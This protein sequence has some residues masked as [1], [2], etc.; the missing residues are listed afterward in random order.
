M[1]K[2]DGRVARQPTPF[3]AGDRAFRRIHTAEGQ[4]A[5]RGTDGIQRHLA[6]VVARQLSKRITLR[7][8]EDSRL[9]RV[10]AAVGKENERHIA[11]I[12]KR[13]ERRL[14]CQRSKAR[15]QILCVGAKRELVRD[16]GIRR[17]M[18]IRIRGG[19]GHGRWS[20]SSRSQERPDI[21]DRNRGEERRCDP[22]RRAQLRAPPDDIE[23]EGRHQSEG[24]HGRQAVSRGV[25]RIHPAEL[26]H[27]LHGG[28]DEQRK[29]RAPPACRRRNAEKYEQRQRNGDVFRAPWMEDESGSDLERRFR[30]ARQRRVMRGEVRCLLALVCDHLRQPARGIDEREEPHDRNEREGQHAGDALPHA[31]HRPQGDEQHRDQWNDQLRATPDRGRRPDAESQGAAFVIGVGKLAQ[32][33]QRQRQKH[34]GGSIRQSERAVH[35]H[36]RGEVIEEGGGHREVG[37]A[38]P[39]AECQGHG[40]ESDGRR[41]DAEEDQ[42]APRV[43]GQRVKDLSDQ[44]VQGVAGRMRVVSR[45]VKLPHRLGEQKLVVFPRRSRRGEDARDQNDQGADDFAPPSP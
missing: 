45:R 40:D 33:Q 3:V 31:A 26:E 10:R 4:I 32:R 27:E 36:A 43:I 39:A 41:D 29:Q 20:S 5:F 2:A 14:D 15:H 21:P 8:G 12:V 6:I 38:Q 28:E 22:R 44:D 19:R 11:A 18:R 17:E 7:P 9:R 1:W 37:I 25:G 16:D 34:D 23:P 42:C 13:G 35:Q 30:A 24:D